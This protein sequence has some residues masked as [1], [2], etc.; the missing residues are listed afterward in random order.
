MDNNA[1]R[2]RVNRYI[3]HY[4]TPNKFFAKQAGVHHTNFSTWVNGNL[5]FSLRTLA[6]I[7]NYID[8]M[9]KGIAI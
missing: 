5:D 9:I 8:R 1:T 4:G 7:N 3:E 2:A 6:K